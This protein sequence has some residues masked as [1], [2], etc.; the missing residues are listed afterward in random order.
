[1]EERAMCLSSSPLLKLR[2]CNRA[3]DAS[4]QNNDLDFNTFAFITRGHLFC[5]SLSLSAA[6][7]FVSA[8]R[9]DPLY[10]SVSCLAELRSLSYECSAR[11]VGARFVAVE[12][13]CGRTSKQHHQ[14]PE[15][16][17]CLAF[18]HAIFHVCITRIYD[19]RVL[20]SYG[21]SDGSVR[22]W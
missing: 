18:A 11:T 21:V 12:T 19:A 4:R 8:P 20:V 1:M 2:A 13:R 17:C 9:D 10:Y 22:G 14:Q 3:Y 15:P 16:A 5:R 6:P 7:V